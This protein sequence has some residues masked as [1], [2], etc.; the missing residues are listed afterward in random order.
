[1]RPSNARYIADYVSEFEPHY[2][3]LL[4]KIWETVSEAAPQA[5][6]TIKYAMPTLVLNGN[7]LHFAAFKNHMG[8]YPGPGAIRYFSEELAPYKTSKGAIQFP[9]HQ[10]L[11]LNLIREIVL[12]R[13]A[14]QLALKK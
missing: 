1:M 3:E 7:L 5:T 11:P 6:E 13:V 8:F 4:I 14:E 10:P 2:Q 9:L 12:F